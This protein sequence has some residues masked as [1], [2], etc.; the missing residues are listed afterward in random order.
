VE[1]TIQFENVSKK[2]NLG[3]TRTSLPTLVSQQLKRTLKRGK[4]SPPVR[5][6]SFWALKDVSF[7]LKQGQS[8]ALVGSNGAGKTTILRLL[9][10]IS[11]PTLGSI[12][13]KGQLSAL[14]ELGAGFHSDLTGR[15][16]VFLNGTIL[17]LRRKDIVKR[18]DEIIAFSELERF[19]DTP[20]KRYSSGMV[21]RLGFAVASCIEPEILLIDEVL[22][23]G[24]ASF[25][26]KCMKR[27]RSLVSNGTSIIFVS[28]NL[29]LVQAICNQSLY[30]ES[31]QLKYHGE[32][33]TVIDM[34]QQDLYK[35]RTLALE[36]SSVT[37]EDNDDAEPIEV[38]KVEVWGTDG[39]TE[40]ALP[41]H[42]PAQIRVYYNADQTVG[43]VHMSVFIMRSDGITCCMLRTKLDDFD[44]Y[45][46]RGSGIV[47]VEIDPLQLVGGSYY[48]EAGFLNNTDSMALTEKGGRS[49]WFTVTGT[50]LSYEESSGV[51][52]ARSKWTHQTLLSSGNSLDDQVVRL[53]QAEKNS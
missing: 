41:N 37:G 15:E 36:N 14:I 2:Y 30:L 16:N 8:L 48:A 12:Q 28:H 40:E 6:K 25:Q 38:T 31:G 32:T 53:V 34:Y 35:K 52:E 9:A 42:Q 20:V 21:V 22:A 29:Y 4:N 51:F 33:K 1:T 27:I 45:V 50:A 26:Q 47:T 43:K 24:D 18:L 11:K 13:T 49:D 19:I 5:E 7:E 17:G 23:V 46:E 44:L 39:P 3:L 10:N